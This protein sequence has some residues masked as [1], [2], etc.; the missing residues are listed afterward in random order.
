M[1]KIRALINYTDFE[2]NKQIKTGEEY[3]VTKERAEVLLKGNASSNNKPFV[4][5]VSERTYYVE[6]ADLETSKVEKAVKTT[7]KRKKK[8]E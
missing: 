3:E 4:E 2:L 7:T 6:T 5:L 8:S 1:V